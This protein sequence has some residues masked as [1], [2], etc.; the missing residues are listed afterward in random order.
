[1]NCVQKGTC[2]EAG[3]GIQGGFIFSTVFLVIQ[4]SLV[5]IAAVLVPYSKDKGRRVRRTTMTALTVAKGDERGQRRLCSWLIYDFL[6][7]ALCA[8]LFAL[9]WMYS[10][11]G[12]SPDQYPG[13]ISLPE[14][15]N[16]TLTDK[17]AADLSGTQ[18][19]FLRGAMGQ[20]LFRARVYWIRV[21]YGLLCLPWW[22]LKLPMMFPIIL[23][24]HPTSYNRLGQTVP[25]A[26]QTEKGFYGHRCC[27]CKDD[28]EEIILKQKEFA[29]EQKKKK[30][31]K[32]KI[33]S[34]NSGASKEVGG[35]VNFEMDSSNRNKR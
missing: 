23:H 28:S 2:R 34:D 10:P 35:S 32:K 26:N 18:K 5:Y 14:A 3:P 25:F 31:K 22:G 17:D 30:K 15:Q 1:M 16:G 21:L 6:T 33:G 20:D 27:K 4:A 24:A 19:E 11:D 8:A 7:V 13:S 12:P 29:K 9:A